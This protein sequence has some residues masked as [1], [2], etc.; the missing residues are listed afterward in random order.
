MSSIRQTFSSMSNRMISLFQNDEQLRFYKGMYKYNVETA[1]HD[2][3]FSKLS[4]MAFIGVLFSI[5]SD[6]LENIYDSNLKDSGSYAK[7]YTA[8]TLDFQIKD[9]I[10]TDDTDYYEIVKIDTSIGYTTLILKVLSWT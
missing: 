8:S 1:M 4:Y 2:L 10:S 3:I 6:A 9:R 5:T 7:L